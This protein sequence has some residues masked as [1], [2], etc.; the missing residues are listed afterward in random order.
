ML[1]YCHK[2]HLYFVWLWSINQRKVTENVAEEY[3]WQ[4]SVSIL[5]LLNL[6][7]YKGYSLMVL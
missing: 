2:Q 4:F 5:Q 7:I 1:F 6:M 3:K